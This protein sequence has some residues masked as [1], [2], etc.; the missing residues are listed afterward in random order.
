MDTSINNSDSLVKKE[1]FRPV[2]LPLVIKKDTFSGTPKLSEQVPNQGPKNK[3][4]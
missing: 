2:F 1:W 4:P 3:K